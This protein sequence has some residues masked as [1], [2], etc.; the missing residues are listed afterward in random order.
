MSPVT[1]TFIITNILPV[2]KRIGKYNQPYERRIIQM[3]HISKATD[4]PSHDVLFL[5]K[6]VPH[7]NSLRAG[8]IVKLTFT[9]D[10]SLSKAGIPHTHIIPH[11]V[12]PI[13]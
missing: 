12:I 9:V 3:R 5:R 10:V 4:Y 11:K 13:S 2:E 6:S 8:Q 7:T 1:E